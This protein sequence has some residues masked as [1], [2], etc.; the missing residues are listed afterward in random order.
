M[1]YDTKIT[2]A[3]QAMICKGY[4]IL[5][6]KLMLYVRIIEHFCDKYDI[7]YEI[8]ICEH[9]GMKNVKLIDPVFST[10]KNVRVIRILATYPNPFNYNMIQSHGFNECIRQA[11]G[12]YCAITSA[13]TFLSENFFKYISTELANK[14][15]YR[16]ATYD[17]PQFDIEHHAN[18]NKVMDVF[19][20]N[21][22]RLWNS[23]TLKENPTP[24]E[25]GEKSGDIMVLD[26][27][28]WRHI[29][30]WPEN[31]CYGHVDCSVCIVATNN[32]P[33]IVPPR[34][35]CSFTMV[36]ETRNS[37]TSWEVNDF[38]WRTCLSYSD[39]KFSN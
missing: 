7:P 37:T 14:T 15:F 6:K 13:D 18:I 28:S 27:E 26:T 24:L 16:F 33:A 35:I 2:F 5:E 30:G 34:E 38:E 25:L 8:I 12:E 23:G 19:E 36:Q 20:N 17:V 9:V 29:K 39:K 31:G 3:T 22:L 32:Y 21:K 1:K 11:K 4:E 10:F